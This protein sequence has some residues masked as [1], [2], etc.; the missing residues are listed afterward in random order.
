MFQ[1]KAPLLTNVVNLKLL[2]RCFL[3]NPQLE[4]L[5]NKE[6]KKLDDYILN[7]KGQEEIIKL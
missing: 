1:E 4:Q 5:I 7:N 2:G 3:T 6:N